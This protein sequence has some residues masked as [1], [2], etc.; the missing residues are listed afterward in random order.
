[1]SLRYYVWAA[2]SLGDHLAAIVDSK[3]FQNLLANIQGIAPHH[4]GGWD[5]CVHVKRG[6]GS[7]K[8]S[9]TGHHL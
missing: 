7:I 5:E 9:T 1:M 8:L 3:L 2:S 6:S 4:R